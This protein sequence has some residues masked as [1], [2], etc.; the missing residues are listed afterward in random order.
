MDKDNKNLNTIFY[1]V[2]SCVAET[3]TTPIYTITTNYQTSNKSILQITKDIYK[4]KNIFGFYNSV[5]YTILSRL[6]SSGVKYNLY[7]N[8]KQYRNTQNNNL[9]NNMINSAISGCIGGIISHPIDVCVN[10]IQ[11]GENITFGKKLFS[12]LMTTIMRNLLLY[13]LL[14]SM[15]DFIKYK[16]NNTYIS[17]LVTSFITTSIMTPIEYIRANIMTGTIKY[18]Q[19]K[20]KNSYKGFYLNLA[21]NGIHFTITMTILEKLSDGFLFIN[22]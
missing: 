11:R 8:L 3:L 13:S 16:T 15:F 7:Q 21:R 9:L 1:L 14:F 5:G 2:G 20:L 4:Q 12:G 17:C 18:N 10:Y 22:E 6:L 19:I